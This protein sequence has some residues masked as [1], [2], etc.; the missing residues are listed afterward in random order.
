MRF[1]FVGELDCP[2]WVLA[3]ISLLS[4]LTSIKLKLFAQ[5]LAKSLQGTAE[6][7]SEKAQKFAAD[8]KFSESDLK[9]LAFENMFQNF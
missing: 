7:D 8:A 1:R 4:R 9:G 5:L 3:E 6:F 2:D